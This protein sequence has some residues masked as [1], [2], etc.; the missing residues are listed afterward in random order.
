MRSVSTHRLA[1]AVA[2][3]A[4]FA[5]LSASTPSDADPI[6][7]YTLSDL[8]ERQRAL[9]PACRDKLDLETELERG[10]EFAVFGQTVGLLC[11]LEAQER[12]EPGEDPDPPSPLPSPPALQAYWVRLVDRLNYLL[13]NVHNQ[14]V[15]PAAPPECSASTQCT[16]LPHT[17]CCE[18]VH[19]SCKD[20]ANI[21]IA[22]QAAFLLAYVMHQHHPT[23]LQV[24]IDPEAIDA[25]AA[26]ARHPVLSPPLLPT[27]PPGN[28]EIPLYGLRILAGEILFDPHLINRGV[29]EFYASFEQ[30]GRRSFA[31]PTAPHYNGLTIS[32]LSLLRDAVHSGLRADV[33]QLLAAHFLVP[34]HPYL[35]GGGLGAVQDRDKSGGGI[36]D[37][38]PTGASHL[39]PAINLFVHDPALP[40]ATGHERF[41]L[42][43]TYVVPEIIRSI[44]LDKGTDPGRFWY[45]RAAAFDTRNGW[46]QGLFDYL[47]NGWQGT[48][49]GSDWEIR[50]TP[51]EAV[52]LPDGDA[53]MGVGYGE[54]GY[55]D[56]TSGLYLRR[57]G[58]GDPSFSILYHRLPRPDASDP[59]VAPDPTDGLWDSERSASARRMLWG[60]T[61]VTL[62]NLDDQ[63]RPPGADPN[64]L[65]VQYTEAHLPDFC[66]ASV[67]DECKTSTHAGQKWYLARS[68]SAYVAF[69]ALGTLA[70]PQGETD[71][72]DWIYLKLDS[73]ISGNVTVL[74]TMDEYPTL[75]DFWE[76]IKDR[77]LSFGGGEVEFDTVD[78]GGTT[79]MRLSYA[80]EERA[81]TVDPEDP[82]SQEQILYDDT[83]DVYFQAELLDSPW[84]TWDE[85]G[86]RF[87][88]S[89]QRAEYNGGDPLVFDYGS[90]TE[91]TTPLE[92]SLDLPRGGRDG[93][94]GDVSLKWLHSWDDVAIEKYSVYYY[95]G[96]LTPT[97]G[98]WL[99]DVTPTFDEPWDDPLKS[100]RAQISGGPADDTSVSCSR[101]IFFGVEAWD[102]EKASPHRAF[103][104]DVPVQG[105]VGLPPG[106]VQNLGVRPAN[107]RVV[108]A[109]DPARDDCGVAGYHVS[110]GGGTPVFVSSSPYIDTDVV[111]SMTYTYTIQAEDE[112]GHVSTNGPSIK[113][114]LCADPDPPTAVTSAVGA[115][116]LYGR[117]VTLT[118][119]PATD[120]CAVLWYKVNRDGVLLDRV[121]AKEFE[122]A[123]EIR[124][125]DE[126]VAPGEHYDYEI[127]ATD[128][129]GL[130]SSTVPVPVD[131]AADTE[132]PTPPA[133]VTGTPTTGQIDLAWE[134]SYDYWGVAGY[135]VV[136]DPP[137]ASSVQVGLDLFYA[138][139][140]VSSGVTYDYTIRATDGGGNTADSET[141]SVTAN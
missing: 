44:Y 140:D 128:F 83:T 65:L 95:D 6:L 136:R 112:A 46:Y 125:T 101:K 109:W 16:T 96:W 77:H 63:W 14:V 116:D 108:L 36:S 1:V 17:A 94:S 57:P 20:I 118:W 48:I 62:W 124:F 129:D 7:K 82:S 23:L 93:G 31:E 11:E 106:P 64:E 30:V 76:D 42:A 119:D 78:G 59:T 40:A 18:W 15:C 53:Q 121:S 111:Q 27:G 89:I 137:F 13:D 81:I 141:V 66:D 56:A 58:A 135:E 103:V 105:D 33:D 130:R 133:N 29:G 34:A 22:R 117:S 73:T 45:R 67:A 12:L 127:I 139:T 37:P 85:S 113:A 115:E 138:D 47:S 8:R 110:R 19:Q 72:G 9:L 5:A 131:T 60:D 43:S 52:I 87:Q 25:F 100:V 107:T 102:G 10:N 120:G 26:L 74:G 97:T 104:T 61:S 2:V 75:D 51:W 79:R 32:L 54:R 92:A 35:P 50:S 114:S 28:L 126:S 90:T 49:G 41:A 91:P 69:T 24:P 4:T 68:G 99:A 88:L 55:H 70:T 21:V 3:M 132:A 98:S 38:D 86:G 84:V 134:A 122:Y 39:I 123:D 71:M 80:P